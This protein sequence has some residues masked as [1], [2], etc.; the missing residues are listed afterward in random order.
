MD[1]ERQEYDQTEVK[2]ERCRSQNC[3]R[4]EVVSNEV[5]NENENK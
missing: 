5:S 4:E 3:T 1:E 2:N